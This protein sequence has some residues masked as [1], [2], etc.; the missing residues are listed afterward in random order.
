ME[1]KPM[2][3]KNHGLALY[4]FWPRKRSSLR[5]SRHSSLEYVMGASLNMRND[6]ELGER[7]DVMVQT[8][9]RRQEKRRDRRRVRRSSRRDIMAN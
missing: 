5:R 2:E 8:R 6:H 1:M 3:R 4:G 9:R 7:I